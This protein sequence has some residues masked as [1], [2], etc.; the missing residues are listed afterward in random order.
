MPV[1][2]RPGNAAKCVAQPVLDAKQRRRTKGQIDADNH[3]AEEERKAVNQKAL[4]GLKRIAAAQEKAALTTMKAQAN[5]PKPRPVPKCSSTVTQPVAREP[6][7][8]EMVDANTGLPEAIGETGDPQ[9]EDDADG[10]EENT[11]AHQARKKKKT[12]VHRD[13]IN[14][15]CNDVARA[16]ELDKKGNLKSE[17]SGKQAYL[18]QVNK[19]VQ[20]VGRTKQS[21]PSKAPRSTAS[22]RVTSNSKFSAI[23]KITATSSAVPPPTSVTSLEDELE[24]PGFS[25][26]TDDSAERKAAHILAGMKTVSEVV[27][28]PD[29]PLAEVSRDYGKPPFTQV[30]VKREAS[31]VS[32]LEMPPPSK[33]SRTTKYS[34]KESSGE[35]KVKYKNEHLPNGCLKDNKWRRVLI[36]TYAKWNG[37]LR[38]G[39]GVRDIEECKALRIIWEAVYK[40][41]IPAEIVSDDPVHFV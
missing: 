18:G 36:P 31:D 29:S 23:S 15:I 5:P 32:I 24:D 9:M 4:Q 26:D 10:E 20:K 21:V 19:W 35:S 37:A 11:R 16:S 28:I 7:D 39:W 12:Q 13:A 6:E 40:G 22:S 27:M 2:T 38:I 17:E 33:R 41:K 25:L 30:L 14:A 3:V 1:T 8:I 34:H